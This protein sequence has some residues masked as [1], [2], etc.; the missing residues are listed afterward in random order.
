MFKYYLTIAILL[1]IMILEFKKFRYLMS[2]TVIY[3]VMWIFSIIG[4]L[5]LGSK[6]NEIHVSTFL[7]IVS[8][9]LLFTLGFNLAYR[10]EEKKHAQMTGTGTGETQNNPEIRCIR[11]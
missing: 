8:G 2:A 7:I 9:Y 10:R 5:F 6:V 4:L 11:Y 3:P 1:F